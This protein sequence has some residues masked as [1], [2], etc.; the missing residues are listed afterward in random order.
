MEH[1]G[2]EAQL[3]DI[4]VDILCAGTCPVRIPTL[5]P[6]AKASG[7]VLVLHDNFGEAFGLNLQRAVRRLSGFRGVVEFRCS[8]DIAVTH[9][10]GEVFL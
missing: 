6:L 3:L 9:V 4:A 7:G 8:G 2:H 5:Q 1:L 10:I